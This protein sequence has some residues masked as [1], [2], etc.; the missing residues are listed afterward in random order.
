MTRR[1]Q[2]RGAELA[3]IGLVLFPG[4]AAAQGTEA[5]LS[6]LGAAL[7]ASMVVVAVGGLFALWGLYKLTRRLVARWRAARAH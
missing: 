4:A 1:L 2:T 3:L 5:A 6:D 7:V